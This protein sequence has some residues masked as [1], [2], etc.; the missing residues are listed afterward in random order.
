MRSNS[1]SA[2]R[3]NPPY[4]NGMGYQSQQQPYYGGNQAYMGQ[5]GGQKMGG[6]D[7]RSHSPYQKS[8]SQNYG[9][10]RNQ[11]QQG[12]H[13][14]QERGMG[15]GGYGGG[16]YGQPMMGNNPRHGG[17]YRSNQMGNRP[18]Y[19]NPSNSQYP[20]NYDYQPQNPPTGQN[21]PPS[22]SYPPSNYGPNQE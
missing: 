2:S 19:N 11:Y 8:Y 9:N 6:Y 21:F 13:Y 20:N 7:N 3:S 10:Q 4:G 22:T 1:N 17:G 5:Q 18:P 14:S 16:N 15:G 12:G